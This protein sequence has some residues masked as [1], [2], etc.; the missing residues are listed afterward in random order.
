[1]ARLAQN[2]VEDGLAKVCDPALQHDRQADALKQLRAVLE[3][4]SENM[5]ARA[6]LE[7]MRP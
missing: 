7:E 5:E 6:L 3:K 2:R 4:R 1:M